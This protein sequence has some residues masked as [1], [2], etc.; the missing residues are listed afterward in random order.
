MNCSDGVGVDLRTPAER[1]PAT[2]PALP[3]GRTPSA[4][5]GPH[6]TAPKS[7]VR[8]ISLQQQASDHWRQDRHERDDAMLHGVCGDVLRLRLDEEWHRDTRR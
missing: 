1:A 2:N 7:A 8:E 4:A 5:P 6:F 3:S